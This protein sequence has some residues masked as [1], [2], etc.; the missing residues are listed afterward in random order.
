MSDHNKGSDPAAGGNA[1]TSQANWQVVGKLAVLI[2]LMFG[3][4]YAMVPIYKAICEVTGVNFLT[5]V[6]PEA[7]KFAGN[8]QV[9]ESRTVTVVFDSNNRGAMKIKP[10][11]GYAEM[12][13][14]QLFT[15]VYDLANVGDQKTSGQAI[16]SYVPAGAARYFR[17]IECF[18][19]DQQTLEPHSARPFQVVFV[20]DPELPKDINTITLSYTYFEVGG[21]AAVPARPVAIRPLKSSSD[22]VIHG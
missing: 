15:V 16:P 11:I 17:K 12:H 20:I 1:T 19:F 2:F 22:E 6:D 13:P 21:I 4:G 7:E 18:C 8:T 3:F 9:D 5:R 10:E 14:G